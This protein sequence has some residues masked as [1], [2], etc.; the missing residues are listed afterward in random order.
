MFEDVTKKLDEFEKWQRIA[1]LSTFAVHKPRIF[2]QGRDGNNAL[3]GQYV[4]G[5]YKEAKAEKGVTTVNLEGVVRTRGGGWRISGSMKKDYQV[6]KVGVVA[7]GF[8]NIKEAEKADFNEKRYGKEI[9]VLTESEAK[10]YTD[11]LDRLIFGK[12]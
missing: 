9:F 12:G 8:S 2:E 6:T 1:A 4:D 5:P 7:Y 10:L 3:I 11:T